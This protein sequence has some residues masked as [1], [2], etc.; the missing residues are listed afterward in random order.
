CHIMIYLL[1]IYNMT[2]LSTTYTLYLHDAL[3]ISRL[4]WKSD[5]G[6]PMDVSLFQEATQFLYGNVP[7]LNQQN[8]L[9]DAQFDSIPR[10][11]DMYLDV[12]ESLIR[13]LPHIC[14]NDLL[15][16]YNVNH[17]LSCLLRKI[18]TNYYG[19]LRPQF[20]AM[21]YQFQKENLQE[22]GRLSYDCRPG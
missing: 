19:G 15:L 7:R 14:S 16:L 20:V 8:A 4:D 5:A 1:Y 21:Q 11:V 22:G 17:L 12:I 3:P 13:Y 2:T 10:S 18:Y 6:L 9:I